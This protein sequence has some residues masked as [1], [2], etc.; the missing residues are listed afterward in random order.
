MRVHVVEDFIA[1]PIGVIE[2]LDGNTFEMSI[3]SR[4]VPQPK[5]PNFAGRGKRSAGHI[6]PWMRLTAPSSTSSCESTS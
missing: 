5:V 1:V 4:A 2:G 6:T 3:L